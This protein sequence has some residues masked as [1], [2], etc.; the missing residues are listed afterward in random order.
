LLFIRLSHDCHEIVTEG[1]ASRYTLRELG[2][3]E[4]G[5][6]SARDW[7]HRGEGAGVRRWDE[8]FIAR[9]AC[10]SSCYARQR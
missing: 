10:L 1:R 4:Y 5:S 9:I 3:I 7:T 8:N 2:L 6:M